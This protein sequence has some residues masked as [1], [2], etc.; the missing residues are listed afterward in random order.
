[1]KIVNHGCYTK[2]TK[3]LNFILNLLFIKEHM[4]PRAKMA[5]PRQTLYQ[6]LSSDY[7]NLCVIL[8]I[9]CSLHLLLGCVE[10]EPYINLFVQYCFSVRDSFLCVLF[11]FLT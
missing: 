10:L 2:K 5:T 9:P 4:Q 3:V 7:N 8:E 6:P 11:L 1:M